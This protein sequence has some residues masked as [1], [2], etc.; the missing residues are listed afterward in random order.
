L[1]LAKRADSGGIAYEIHQLR[2]LSAYELVRENNVV[3]NKELLV[4]LGLDKLFD[5]V[6][7]QSKNGKRK[8]PVK[9]GQP[10]KRGKRG[11]G[12]R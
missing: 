6:M 12:Q 11:R 3:K 1:A 9:K 8:A 4:A 10:T 2:R 5:E 7:G